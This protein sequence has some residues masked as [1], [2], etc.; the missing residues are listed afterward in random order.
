MLTDIQNKAM[1][2][3]IGPTSFEL[4]ICGKTYGCDNRH[5]SHTSLEPEFFFFLQI[6]IL[7]KWILGKTLK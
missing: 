3:K 5:L 7:A 1:L 6:F 4:G 2:K